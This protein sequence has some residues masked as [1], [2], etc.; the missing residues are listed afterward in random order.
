MKLHEIA[1]FQPLKFTGSNRIRTP[2]DGLATLY[3]DQEVEFQQQLKT[4]QQAAAVE[5]RKKSP[6][7]AARQNKGRVDLDSIAPFGWNARTG[8]EFKSAEERAKFYAMV[9]LADPRLARQA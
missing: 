5:L 2:A 8:E 4:A 9:G 7:P 1:T 3:P 6:L